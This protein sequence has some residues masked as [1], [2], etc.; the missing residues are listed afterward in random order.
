MTT[1]T[2]DMPEKCSCYCHCERK[3]DDHTVK[4]PDIHQHSAK[5]NHCTP[6]EKPDSE[7][8]FYS[9]HANYMGTQ[10]NCSD[11]GGCEAGKY[12]Q[13]SPEEIEEPFPDQSRRELEAAKELLKMRDYWKNYDGSTLL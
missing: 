1:P 9:N 6:P 3:F 5:C 10:K 13:P 4:H 2:P 8:C 11:C 12:L 7:K